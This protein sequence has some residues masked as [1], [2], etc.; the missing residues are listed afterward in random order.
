M[1]IGRIFMDARECMLPIDGISSAHIG[2][3]PLEYDHGIMPGNLETWL[4]RSI[5]AA[6]YAS[7]LRSL[8]G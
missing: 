5:Q 6:L 1:E 7:K 2:D 8:Q 4:A 3:D